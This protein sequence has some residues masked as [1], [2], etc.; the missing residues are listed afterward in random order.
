MSLSIV[1]GKSMRR[2]ET[3]NAV[4]TTLASPTQG[5]TKTVS[6]WRIVMQPGQQGPVT[7]STA[8]RSGTC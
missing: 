1:R 3:P 8:S 7:S 4:M 2:S 6:A 5:G